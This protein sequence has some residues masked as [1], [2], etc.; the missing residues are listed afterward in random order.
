[1][2]H[3]RS[4]IASLP[5]AG[6]AALLLAAGLTIMVGCVLAPAL[7]AI[8]A[9][10]GV[11]GAASW[12]ITLPSLG[13][14]LFSP[15]TG[16]VITRLGG[17]RA[18]C[19]GSLFYGL[20]GVAGAA[21]HGLAAVVADRLLLGAATAVVMSSG[22][23]LISEFY[24]GD[25]RL[26]M[27]VR[28][29]MAIE[30]GG[31]VFLLIAGVL[32]SWSWRG[33]FLLYLFAWIVAGV[34]ARFVPSRP[35]LHDEPDDVAAGPAA[36]L[37]LAGPY[38]AALASMVVFVTA[39]VSLPGRLGG[40]G[41]DAPQ[42]GLFL[43][44]ISLVAVG[45]AFLMPRV[46]QRIGDY[47]TLALAFLS[48]AVAHLLYLDAGSAAWMV[49]GALFMGCG[50]GLSIPLVNHM[51]IERSRPAQR[52]HALAYLST[53][54]FL[55]QFLS[56]FVASLSIHGRAFLMAALLSGLTAI[57]FAIASCRIPR[58]QATRS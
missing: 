1:M 25:A 6:A 48:Y 10:L 11:G 9:G 37:P 21:L 29:G 53:A 55:G 39:I 32:A 31:V 50:F 14:V 19:V 2:N 27:I 13:V 49:A 41:F 20:F 5:P 17:Q 33:P 36:M 40:I 45:F 18:L 12:L 52:A 35:H 46:T 16:R 22:T 3:S 42:T 38:L 54:I 8:A 23:V 26:G 15:L 30:L 56:T 57:G 51:T 44:F 34:V 28:Q 24:E 43:S 7:P 4:G 47:A 58:L